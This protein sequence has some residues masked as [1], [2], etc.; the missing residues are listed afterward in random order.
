[1]LFGM[2]NAPESFQNMINEILND[3]IDLSVV[4]YINDF[5][6]YSQTKVENE[7][8]VKEVLSRLKK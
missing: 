1:M 2:V 5:L 7:R 4:A 6:I 3:M 8:L